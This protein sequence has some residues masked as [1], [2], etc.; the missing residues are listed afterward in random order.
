MSNNVVHFATGSIRL[1][2]LL[3]SLGGSGGTTVVVVVVAAWHNEEDGEE[4]VNSSSFLLLVPLSDD[5][6]VGGWGAGAIVIFP[7]ATLSFF[8]VCEFVLVVFKK[9]NDNRS[10]ERE[11]ER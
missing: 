9:S 8:C 6:D 7:F 2:L 10:I 3:L 1:H 11:R 5:D 4:E